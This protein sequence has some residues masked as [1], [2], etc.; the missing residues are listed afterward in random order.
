MN[1]NPIR[2]FVACLS[3]AFGSFTYAADAAP[4]PETTAKP[5][6]TVKRDYKD[7]FLAFA[8]EKAEKYSGTAEQVVSKAVDTATKEAPL[9]AREFIIWRAWMH[10]IKG[11]FPIVLFTVFLTLF[12]KQWGKWQDDGY[13]NLKKGTTGNVIATVVGGIGSG[14]TGVASVI[15][16]DHILSFVQVLVAPRVYMVEQVL[17]LFGK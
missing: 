11:V 14:V 4:N 16:A 12:C 17:N 13:G 1:T 10:A 15:C 2:L 9:L 7:A 8:L 6:E 5:A 3:L